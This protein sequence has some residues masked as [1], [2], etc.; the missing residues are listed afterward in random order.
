MQPR[1]LETL[2]AL[3][4]VAAVLGVVAGAVW[5]VRSGDDGPR[6]PQGRPP[7]P[8]AEHDP[9]PAPEP[10]R[11]PP[12]LVTKID[13]GDA[14]T[15]HT[16]LGSA[17]AM[18]VEP[19]EGG[20]TMLLAVHWSERPDVLGPVSSARQTDLELLGQFEDPV[21]AYSG[22]APAL[23]PLVTSGD[24]VSAT[25]DAVPDAFYRDPDQ[26]ATNDLYARPNQLPEAPQTRRPF[27]TGA[28]PAGGEATGSYRV[29]YPSDTYDFTWSPDRRS[30]LVSRNRNAF[31]SAE[32]GQLGAET[33]VVLDV[34]TDTGLGIT[35]AA[36][37]LSPSPARSAKAR[38]RYSVTAGCT[39]AHGN[40]PM[41]PT[42]WS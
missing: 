34:S 40:A 33:V 8:T 17:G 29:S 4:G 12:A 13:T 6:P 42:R 2:I 15:R 1:P 37:R 19:V 14:D 41:P 21:L 25:P 39:R 27:P 20:L 11:F 30:W 36:G 26:P 18:V 24:A 31:T 9:G 38:P 28:P 16:G 5:L 3:L 22:A 7:P 35:D 10:E 23:L 32:H